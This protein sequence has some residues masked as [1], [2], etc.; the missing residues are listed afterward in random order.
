MS[1]LYRLGYFLGG[2]S[3]GLVILFFLFNGKRTQCNYGPQARVINNLSEKNWEAKTTLLAGMSLDSTT[4]QSLLKQATVDFSESDT[5]RDSCKRY[6]L[7]GYYRKKE[8]NW[9]VENCA[10]TVYIIDITLKP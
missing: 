8:I 1:F 9:E 7:A 2:F 10:K 3:A 6:A 5:K 4:V